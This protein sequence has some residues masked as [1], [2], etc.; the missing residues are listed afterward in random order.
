MG[1]IKDVIA[2]TNAQIISKHA[3]EK[4]KPFGVPQGDLLG[5]NKVGYPVYNI[6]GQHLIPLGFY[7]TEEKFAEYYMTAKEIT[8]K[9]MRTPTGGQG[10]LLERPDVNA[11]LHYSLDFFRNNFN[12]SKNMK[13]KDIMQLGK[14]MMKD[15]PAMMRG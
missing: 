11:L 10:K 14:M 3:N 5:Y 15:L 6:N 7:V 13:I 9:G 12:L 2:N 4:M 8:D 1:N